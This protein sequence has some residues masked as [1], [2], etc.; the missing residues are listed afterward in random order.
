MKDKKI[1]IGTALVLLLLLTT[2]LSY[3]YFS[4]AVKG[5]DNAK[6]MVVEAGTLKLTY[7]DGP[8]I[9]MNNI[10]PGAA[11][12]KTIYVAN[13]G[14]LNASYNLV[15]QELITEIIND[16]MIIEATCTKINSTTKEVDGTC[17]D[18]ES[19]TIGKIKIKQNVIIEPN[20]IH[21]YN[22]TI[23]FKD[24]NDEQNYN[25]GKKFSGS[26]GINEYVK[27][28][29]IYCTFNGDMVQGAE[30]V[31]GQ[32][33]YSYKQEWARTGTFDY[34]WAKYDGNAD[35]W[36]VTLTDKNSTNSV[37][38][39][40]CTYINDKPVVSMSYMF[41]NSKAKSLDLSSF[42]T[43]NVKNMSFMFQRSSA[44]LLDLSSFN[45][46]NVTNMQGMFEYSK[47]TSIDLSTF[48]TSKVTDMGSMFSNSDATFLDLNT[49]NTS[50]VTNMGHMFEN[51]AANSI[52]LN[53]FNTSKVI[54]MGSMFSS[55][56]ATT[57]DVSSFDT[58][59][60]TSMGNMFN[61][62]FATTIYGLENFDTSKVTAMQG[63][64]NTSNATFL[65]LSSFNTSN[66]IGINGMFAGTKVSTLDLSSFDTSNVEYMSEM[67]Y[68]SSNLKTIYASDKFA[69]NKVKDGYNMFNGCTSLI[70]GAGTKYNSSYIDKT[71]AHIDGGEA[72]PGY[73]TA[74]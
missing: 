39:K 65:D 55:S 51:S 36:G 64:F 37:T 53:N 7:T 54:Y 74:K 68:Y 58:S 4:T 59:N 33:T 5:N 38:S 61:R 27:N 72:N 73:F 56:Q 41:Y 18:L 2:G 23:T 30:Y 52:G 49:F 34:G 12:T 29:P 1:L 9:V 31:N 63:M 67:F 66:V 62:S 47:S 3:A 71:Y 69:I 13:T 8:E 50:N 19:T 20:I 22:I 32:Y 46:S 57:L 10:K 60:V 28:T 16:E 14:T 42:D 11:I 17:E 45:T 15:W 70:G 21:K 24:I 25:Q 26:L 43:S 48:D 44:T 35:G 6:D 40:L